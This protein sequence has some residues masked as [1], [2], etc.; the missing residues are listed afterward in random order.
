MRTRTAGQAVASLAAA[1]VLRLAAGLPALGA[2]PDK[3]GGGGGT[4]GTAVVDLVALGDSYTSG[5]GAGPY[6]DPTAAEIPGNPYDSRF[7]DYPLVTGAADGEAGVVLRAN[8]A[9]SGASTEQIPAQLEALTAS[10]AQQG[11]RPQDIELVTLTVGGID[12]GSNQVAST[13]ANGTVT[14]ACRA[15]LTLTPEESAALSAK[16]AERYSQIRAVFVNAR[17][18]ALGYPRFFTGLY[19]LAGEFPR[20][21]NTSVDSLDSAIQKA[22]RTAGAK[23]VDVRDEFNGHEIGSFSGAWINYG[24]TSDPNEDFHPNATGYRSGYYRALVNDR[25]APAP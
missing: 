1:L 20:L 9:F 8:A 11:M 5:Q 3:P 14:D 2:R 17:V 15:L 13:C 12:A 21:L 4:G 23:F 6:A 18:V 10:L 25:V 22:A 24:N 16:L 19:L 7:Y